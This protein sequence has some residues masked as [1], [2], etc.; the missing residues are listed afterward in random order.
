MKKFKI[1]IKIKELFI[2]GSVFDNVDIIKIKYI[3]GR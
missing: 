3:V 1:R 2:R